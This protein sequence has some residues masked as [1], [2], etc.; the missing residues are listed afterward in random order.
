MRRDGCMA[1]RKALSG[2]KLGQLQCRTVH[3]FHV[4]FT[5]H[6]TKVIT[7]YTV[8]WTMDMDRTKSAPRSPDPPLH[9]AALIKHVHWS[10]TVQTWA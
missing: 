10:S 8:L 7:G 6:F 3:R 9:W 5:F 2:C 4:R 1:L